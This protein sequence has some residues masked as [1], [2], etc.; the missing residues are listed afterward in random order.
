MTA[1]DFDRTFKIDFYAYRHLLMAALPHSQPGDTA[2]ATATEEALKGSETMIDY[3]APKA[4]LITLPKSVAIHLAQ[5]GARERRG[6]RPDLD[7]AQRGRPTHTS[8]TT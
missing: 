4:T 1:E 2:I 6:A 3:A 8:R 5:R 7:A